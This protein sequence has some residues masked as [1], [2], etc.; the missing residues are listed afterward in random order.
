MITLSTAKYFLE[1]FVFQKNLRL[2]L[3]NYIQFDTSA[4]IA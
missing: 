1:G 3:E 2:N 4:G